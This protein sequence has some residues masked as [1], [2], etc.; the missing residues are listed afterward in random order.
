VV[1]WSAHDADGY[2]VFARRFSNSGAPVGLDFQVNT[3]TT[4]TQ[5]RPAIAADADGDFLVL[6]QSR[7]QDGGD[8]GLF[9]QRY[10]SAGA[11]LGQE[12]RINTYTPNLQRNASVDME[13]DGDFVVT[14]DSEHDGSFRGVFGRRFSSAGVR[15]AV[16]FQVNTYTTHIQEEPGIAIQPSGDF[17]IVWHSFAQDGDSYGLFAQRFSSA[18]DPIGDEFQ[19]NA[20]AGGVQ[21]Y[22]SVAA[23]SNGEFVIAWQGAVTDY[24]VYARRFS[25]EGTPL[26]DEYVL[27][28]PNTAADVHSSVAADPDGDFTVTWQRADSAYTGDIYGRQVSSLDPSSGMEFQ[29]HNYTTGSQRR[30]AVAADAHGRFVVVWMSNQQDGASYGTFAQRFA[31]VDRLDIDGSGSSELLTDG[32]LFLRYAF[33]FRG[34]LL[35]ESAV[36]H[37]Y[38]TRCTPEAIESYLQSAWSDLDIDG[39]GE[40][41]ALTDSLLAARWLSGLSGSSLTAGAVGEDCVHCEPGEIEARF[42]ALD[43]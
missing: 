2:G 16:E 28:A 30:A 38:C 19:V 29:V 25:A 26:G 15:L 1:A 37:G 8:Y 4:G 23:A 42:E 27:N 43:S 3:Y 21:R 41:R 24:E 14:W 36:A 11:R 40:V 7:F 35:V 18:G 34:E 22:P 32:V 39:D 5:Q 20:V 12:L 6:W 33:G 31:D 9:A 13:D 10:S 17:V